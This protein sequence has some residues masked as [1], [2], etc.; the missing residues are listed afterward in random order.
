MKYFEKVLKYVSN[1]YSV[2]V[3]NGSVALEIAPKV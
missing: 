1:K 2:S 3:S